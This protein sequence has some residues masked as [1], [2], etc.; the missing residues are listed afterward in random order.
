M[1]MKKV[2]ISAL[3]LVGAACFGLFDQSP[4]VNSPKEPDSQ[5]F[6]DGVNFDDGHDYVL[7]VKDG[8]TQTIVT[9]KSVLQAYAGKIR[10]EG[11]NWMVF[12]PGERGSPDKSIALFRDGEAI[13]KKTSHNSKV[14]VF[15]DI[16]QHGTKVEFNWFSENRAATEARISKQGLPDAPRVFL[17]KPPKPYEPFNFTLTGYLPVFWGSP[18]VPLPEIE[19]KLTALTDEHVTPFLAVGT[20]TIP[21]EK[22]ASVRFQNNLNIDL[23]DDND[24]PLEFPDVVSFYR[25]VLKVSCDQHRDCETLRQKLPA[26]YSEIKT[27]RDSAL[28]DSVEHPKLQQRDKDGHR[29]LYLSVNLRDKFWVEITENKYNLSFYEAVE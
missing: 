11:L 8:E 14:F 4:T 16:V 10:A 2:T 13:R 21:V 5:L 25:P 3:L 6:L 12:V 24:A 28:I 9:D 18:K 23:L 20:V 29:S 27:W 19:A 15:S 26:L 22:L 17:L 7:L 1:N